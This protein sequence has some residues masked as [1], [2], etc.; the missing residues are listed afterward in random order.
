MTV[1]LNLPKD[2]ERRLLAEVQAGRHKSVEDA[3]LEKLSRSD[4][5]DLLAAS[6]M[7]ADQLRAD[8][9]R[10]WN[11]RSDAVDGESVFQ[12]IAAKSASLKA[13]GR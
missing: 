12:R 2:L 9:D 1:Q 4:E 8:L 13:Q 7:S 10:A 11:D 3:I 5:P 6:G